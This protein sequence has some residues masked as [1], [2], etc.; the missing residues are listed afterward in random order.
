MIVQRRM[1]PVF[2]AFGVSLTVRNI[3]QGANPCIPYIFCY[4][5]MGGLDPDFIGWEQSYN[6]GH[7]E[8]TFETA[9]RIAGFSRNYAL[10]YY[11]ASGAFSTDGVE[12]L[13][14]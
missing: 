14:I 11:S 7:D 13:S 8:A 3:A 6:C 12:A 4:E 2:D 10:T 9:G 1:A 5:A